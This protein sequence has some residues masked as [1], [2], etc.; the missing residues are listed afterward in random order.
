MSLTDTL[1]KTLSAVTDAGLNRYRLDIPSCTSSLDVEEFS[2]K[3]FLSELYYYNVRFT[4]SDLNIDA[5]QLLNKLA[6]LTMGTGPLMALTGQKVVHGVVTH[7]KRISGSRDQATYQIIIEPFLALLGNQFRTHRF[8]VNKSVPE[9]VAEVLQEHGLRGWEYEFTLRADYPKREQIN[10]Y[11]ENDLE[12]IERL[13]A[14]VGIFYFFTLQPDTLTEVVH[15][16]DKQSAW[17][18]GKKLPLNSPSGAND[19]GADSVWG[20]NVRHNVVARSVTASDYNHREAQNILTSVPADMTRGDGEGNT[21]GDV[22]H[23]R[24]RHLERGDKINPAAE[25]GNFWARL[26]HERFL[27]NQTTITGS[28]T[29]H[30]LG[31]AQVL[32]ITETAIPPTLPRETENGVVIISAG[33]TASRRNALKV[34]WVATPYYE[35]R[36]WRPEAKKRPVVSGT[37]MARVTSGKDND[38]YAWQDASGMY[39]V[40]FD[41]DR[42]DKRQG[43]E[44]MP[45]RFAKPYGGDKYGFHF[46]LIQ[47]TEVA[48]AFHEGDPDRPYIAHALHDSRH[49]DHVTEA[50]STRNVIRT[51]GLNKLRMEDKRGEEHIKLSTE[52]GG[53]TQLNLGHNVDASRKL[54]GEGAEL[55]TDRHV[56]IRGGAGVFITA[57]KQ[58]LAGEKMLSMKEAIAQLENAL[59]IAKSLSSAAEGAEALPADTASQ[60]TLNAALKELAKP[61]IMLNA[62]DGVS[63]TSPQAVRVASGTASVG[64]MSQ[65]NTD[66]SALKRFTV[67][68]GEAVSMLARKAGMKLFAAKGRVEIQAQDDAMEVIAKKDVTVTSLEGKVVITGATELVVNCDGAF[69]K[70]A[71]G[72]ME[73]GA[74]GNILLKC[75]NVQKMG[76]ADY[77]APKPE[78]PQGYSERFVAQDKESGDKLANTRYRITTADGAVYEGRTDS[79]GKTAEIYGAAKS[80]ISIELLG[81]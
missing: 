44:S 69:M 52:Y 70:L 2:G 6:T 33:Y 45:V 72:N 29:D 20:V 74:P 8:F 25:T 5:T 17:T 62:P 32:T 54:R 60:Q 14:E 53:K 63:I 51:A 75:A 65:Q 79:E 50:N 67:A 36:C 22:Y 21:Y 11:Q 37:L 19:N 34:D 58:P 43:M 77:D 76:S 68:A 23:Y 16:A 27:S 31:P 47:G 3:E 15:F 48:I 39:R 73:L 59:T 49:V 13:L 46:P 18:F 10:Q 61:G 24:P 12:F 71:G 4:S 40:K 55:R 57:D 80:K 9:V 66:I 41:A 64:I 28:S 78:L 26:E 56:C 35:N 1:N 42:D 38:I 7:F 30:T 81:G